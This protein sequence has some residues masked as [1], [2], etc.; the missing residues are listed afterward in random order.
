MAAELGKFFLEEEKHSD[1]KDGTPAEVAVSMSFPVVQNSASA[2]TI[3]EWSQGFSIKEKVKLSF[4]N[5]FK[6]FLFML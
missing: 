1:R 4:L 5:H 6:K 3:V 2:K